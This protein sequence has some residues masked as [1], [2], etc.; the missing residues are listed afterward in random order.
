VLLGCYKIRVLAS[1]PH[2]LPA[3]KLLPNAIFSRQT[4]PTSV[5]SRFNSKTAHIRTHESPT[6]RP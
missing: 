1:L 5:P 4:R 6:A 3:F 2:G